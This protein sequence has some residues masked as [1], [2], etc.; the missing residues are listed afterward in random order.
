MKLRNRRSRVVAVL[1]VA[2][3][4]AAL[5]L[6]IASNQPVLGSFSL[7]VLAAT[8]LAISQLLGPRP[9]G[10]PQVVLTTLGTTLVLLV[11]AGTVSAE[12]TPGLDARG[13]AMVELV[14]LA[15]A[16]GVWGWRTRRRRQRVSRAVTV[17][18]ATRRRQHASL[19]EA[20]SSSRGHRRPVEIRLGP[21]SVLLTIVGI[22]LGFTGL[23][24][25]KVAAENQAYAGFV[26]FWSVPPTVGADALMGIRNGA[27]Q[28]LDCEISLTRAGQ[29]EFD[30][31]VGQIGNGES[32][33]GQ[34]PRPSALEGASWQLSLH[35]AGANGATYDRRLNIDPPA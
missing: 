3:V 14:A 22:V 29:P 9:L 7:V 21:G 2:I 6:Q 4:L 25:A 10:W 23:L 35:C 26:Q 27:G 18:V 1:L 28:A 33:L 11:L 13:V 24:V 8:G 20:D 34:L 15:S 5:A 30:W 17:K 32:W 31:H 19:S 12:S 16:A